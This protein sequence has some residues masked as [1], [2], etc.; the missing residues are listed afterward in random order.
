MNEVTLYIVYRV[1]WC[2][3]GCKHN[4]QNNHHHFVS[5]PIFFD[6]NFSPTLQKQLIIL[7]RNSEQNPPISEDFLTSLFNKIFS[8][9]QGQGVPPAFMKH[10]C[11]F[12][13]VVSINKSSFRIY[14]SF[15]DFESFKELFSFLLSTTNSLWLNLTF[16]KATP[17]WF[18]VNGQK[19]LR[20][21]S[22]NKNKNIMDFR[23]NSPKF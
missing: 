12:D 3:R 6:K 7:S 20:S 22:C 21:V 14:S 4:S 13:C 11:C 10:F 15:S 8:W 16:Y 2:D 19:K 23:K 17:I 18:Y 5:I 1:N 9:K